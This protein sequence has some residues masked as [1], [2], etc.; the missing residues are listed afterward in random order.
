ME[1]FV[2]KGYG[3]VPSEEKSRDG[4]DIGTII[5]DSI[6]SPVVKVAVDVE[7]VRVGKRTD[8][9]KLILTIET[10]G[11]I[12]PLEAFLSAAKLLAEQFTSFVSIVKKVVDKK[13]SKKKT[14][15]KKKPMA[16]KK[17]K[18]KKVAKEKPMAKKIVKKKK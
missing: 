11:S 10:D 17:I 8:Y 4:L 5:I 9:D 12:S 14:V 7:N 15:I 16:K 6:F 3:W 13:A 18:V 2:E 1:I